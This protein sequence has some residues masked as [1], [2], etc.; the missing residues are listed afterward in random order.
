MNEINLKLVFDDDN[1]LVRVDV[2]APLFTM[3]KCA[4][5]AAL[6]N[7]PKSFVK[8]IHPSYPKAG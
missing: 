5:L 8:V 7:V 6:L 1:R 4:A 3:S 2:F